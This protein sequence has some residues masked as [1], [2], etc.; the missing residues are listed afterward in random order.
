M[1]E[2]AQDPMIAFEQS[3]V[4]DLAAFYRDLAALSEAKTLEELFAL[5]K[6][7]R[8]RLRELSP[9]MI[10]MKEALALNTLLTAMADSCAYALGR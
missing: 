3:R 2:Q 6:P 10:G 4:A 5:E 9:T 1:A 7:L 8:M